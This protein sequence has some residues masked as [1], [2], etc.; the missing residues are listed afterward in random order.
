M[1]ILSYDSFL[2]ESFNGLYDANVNRALLEA[3]MITEL[4]V[5]SP[6]IFVTLSV[7]DDGIQFCTIATAVALACVAS[8]A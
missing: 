4:P 8:G 7:L 5:N 1:Y 3:P 2:V 6:E